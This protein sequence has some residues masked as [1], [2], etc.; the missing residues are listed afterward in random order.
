MP[1]KKKIAQIIKEL[2]AINPNMNKW[3]LW[4]EAQ[5]RFKEQDADSN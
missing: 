2:V 4:D 1:D 3:L 5:R